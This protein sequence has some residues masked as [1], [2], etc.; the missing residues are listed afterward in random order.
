MRQRQDPDGKN[1]FGQR[2]MGG[3]ADV[4]IT[5]SRRLSGKRTAAEQNS[6]E[7]ITLLH[8]RFVHR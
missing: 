3:G 7:S 4:A 1:N 5:R 6:Y 8:S 2:Q